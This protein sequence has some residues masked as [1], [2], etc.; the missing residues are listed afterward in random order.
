MK[1]VNFE[2]AVAR[3]LKDDP[4]YAPEAYQFAREALDFTYAMLSSKPESGGERHVTGQELLEGMRKYALK[5]FGAVSMTVLNTWG[6]FR[7]EDFGQL[8]FNLVNNGFLRKTEED[9]I[10]DFDGGYDFETA[11]RKPFLP[12]NNKARTP[13][14]HSDDEDD[15][16]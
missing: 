7:C 11:F 16:S 5:E 12:G 13:A 2:E 3:I 10:H 4:R 1:M 6:I 8:I 14:R 15:I 9:S